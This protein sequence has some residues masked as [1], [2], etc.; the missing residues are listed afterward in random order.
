MQ[1]ATGYTATRFFTKSL[2][3]ALSDHGT[4]FGFLGPE[5]GSWYD[6]GKLVFA[7]DEEKGG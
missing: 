1:F 3:K 7:H 6:G 4:S 2:A 5:I